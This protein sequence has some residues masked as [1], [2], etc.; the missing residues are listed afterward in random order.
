MSVFIDKNGVS[1]DFGSL[2][3]SIMSLEEEFKSFDPLFFDSAVSFCNSVTF[4]PISSYSVSDFGFLHFLKKMQ[5]LLFMVL[6]L[7]I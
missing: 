3:F 4:S 5:T 2:V 7:M 1:G 6:T